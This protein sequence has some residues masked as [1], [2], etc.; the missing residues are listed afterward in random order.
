MVRIGNEFQG[1]RVHNSKKLEDKLRML[2]EKCNETRGGDNTKLFN[3]I[4][5]RAM[6]TRQELIVQREAAGMAK[7]S[8]Q[9]AEMVE[10]T[11]PIPASM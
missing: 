5:K 3:A 7:N 11:F 6:A 4:R 1:E 8:V 9:N 2:I 10:A